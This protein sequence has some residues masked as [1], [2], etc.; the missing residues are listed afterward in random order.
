[1]TLW[2][3]TLLAVMGLLEVVFL[4]WIFA[5]NIPHRSADISAFQ[6]YR[7]T[8]TEENKKRWLREREK[9]QREVTIRKSLGAFFAFGNA[10]LMVWVARRQKRPS[11]LD[12]TRLHPGNTSFRP[13]S[14]KDDGR[15]TEHG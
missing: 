3:T 9:T 2:K 13:K 15:S 14:D 12:D 1:M 4:S 10:L 11:S 6:Q 8:P 7:A 5:S